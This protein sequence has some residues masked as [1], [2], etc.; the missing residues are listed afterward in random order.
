MQCIKCKQIID[1]D[2][3][4]CPLCGH[5]LPPSASRIITIGRANDNDHVVSDPRVSGH[6][7]RITIHENGS[8][9]IE[10]LDSSNGTFVNGHKIQIQTLKSGDT[11]ML[12]SSFRLDS[13]LWTHAPKAAL[14]R[15]SG[16]KQTITVGRDSSND[17]VI[18]NI[19]VSRHHARLSKTDSGWQIEDLQSSNGTFVNGRKISRSPITLKDTIVVGG[20]PLDLAGFLEGEKPDFGADLRLVARN[21]RFSVP[22]KTIVEDI[23]LLMKPGQFIGLIG[24]SGCGKT[25]LMMMLNGYLRPSS[26]SVS[27]SGV[28]LY[29]NLQSFQ[30]QMGYV[31]QDDIIHRE[32]KVHESLYYT[33]QL[34]L[35]MKLSEHERQ[36]QIDEIL[37]TLGLQA[38]S[39]T[40]IGTPEKKGISGGQRKRVNMAQE[41]ITEPQFYFL[42]EP[43]SGLDP[44]SDR[45]VMQLLADISKRGHLVLLTTHNIN[46]ANFALLSH[47]IVMTA[48]GKLA[49]Y[50]PTSGVLDYFGI[51]EP[52]EI[53]DV[54]AQTSP[55]TLKDRFL[56]STLY[57]RYSKPAQHLSPDTD[58]KSRPQQ[59]QDPFHQYLTLCKRMLKVKMRDTFSTAVLLLQA[60]IIGIF[61][62]LTFKNNQNDAALLFVLVVATIWLGCSNSA[63]EIVTEQSIFR[64]E[65]KACLSVSA[66][67][68]SKITVL[69]LLCILQCLILAFFGWFTSEIDFLP[70]LGS[71]GLTSISAL[72]M[73]LALSAIVKTSET[74]MALVPV[75]LIPQVIL[76]GLIVP[77]GSIPEV[78]KY[79]AGMMLSRWSFELLLVM[80]KAN[81]MITNHLGFNVDNL[82]IDLILI[83][84]MGVFFTILTWVFLKRKTQ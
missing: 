45:D 70:L 81:D 52:E 63:R 82:A 72:A 23:N 58:S 61:T 43:T 66:Y 1:D 55:N 39:K 76:G 10:D 75:T 65:Q 19:R 30:G 83:A 49:Y 11:V 3:R 42:D 14:P 27:I 53:F 68:W 32:L 24:P 74:A 50:G 67:L 79:L 6:H 38:A 35:G 54:V 33:S 48:G 71:L 44:R 46:T 57:A 22:E 77:F 51:K 31:P 12:G 2:S 47:L 56:Q 84:M 62:H 4:F 20:V 7:C 40:L 29:Q 18:R 15:D 26:G 41:L 8:A 21:L 73:G 59:S 37:K 36:S 69:S 5:K 16:S 64:R 78:G 80:D 28:S 13:S 25:T 9:V 17:V 60:P 34:R